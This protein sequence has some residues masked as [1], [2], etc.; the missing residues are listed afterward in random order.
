MIKVIIEAQ[1]GSTERHV[2]DDVS[3]EHQGIRIV[4]RPYPYAYGFILGTTT[5]DDDGLDC[6]I[7]SA[8]RLPPG[9]IVNCEPIGLLEQLEEGQVDHK[10]IAILAEH[11][12]PSDNSFVDQLREFIVA[13]FV[14][15]PESEVQ[16]GRYRSRAFALEMIRSSAAQNGLNQIEGAG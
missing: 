16:V 13:I 5:A 3:L 12:Q 11:P 2:F 7:I 1:V 15:Y 4:P 6:Y 9:S 10:I 14:A 8:D